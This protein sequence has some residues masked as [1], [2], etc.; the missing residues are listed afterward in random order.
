MTNRLFHADD[1]ELASHS[2]ASSQG[3]FDLDDLDFGSSQDR[4][5][6]PFLDGILSLLA[7]F[8]PSPSAG[9][10]SLKS[11]RAT[12]CSRPFRRLIFHITTFTGLI[13][14]LVILTSIF[15]P[16]YTK[17]PPQYA[18]LRKRALASREPARANPHN[19]T[20]FVAA[21][22]YDDE[23]GLAGGQWGH[24]VLELIDL[25][26]KD[27]VFL[28]IYENGKEKGAKA[29]RDFESQVT[30]N[31]SLVFESRL[32]LG[33]IPAVTVPGGSKRVKRIDLLADVR[34]RALKPLDDNP[35][36]RYD[37]LL[38]LNDVVF[39][40][41]DAAQLLFS[42]NATEKG[43]TQYRAA[44]SVDFVNPFKFY[45]TFATRDLQGYSMGVPFFPW[46]STAGKAESR[47]DVLSGKDAVR[48][49]SCW[50]GMVA[51]D[52]KYFQQNGGSGEQN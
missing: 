4:N 20:V 41:I 38:F 39:D 29:L 31:K 33:S 12:R 27:N 18:L 52:A 3:T 2:S 21:S 48:V 28:S 8:V 30:C 9:Y 14:I 44:C 26:G 32:D 11:T 10:R 19:E 45:D 51:F 23:G 6:W 43:V 37:K 16:S 5:K 25:L 7:R 13:I 17:A 36:V 47:N 42:T 34:N 1:Y 15:Y 24:M 22:L 40:P 50:G 49:R 35:E 46:F